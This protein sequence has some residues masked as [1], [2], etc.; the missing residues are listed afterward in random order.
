MAL[1]EHEI[2][3]VRNIRALEGNHRIATGVRAPV[4]PHNDLLIACIRGPRVGERRVGKQLI[5]RW[6]RTRWRTHV[7]GGLCMRNDLLRG[8]SEGDVAARVIA[9]V[10]RVD[11]EVDAAIVRALIETSETR[12][13]FRRKLAVD[14][15][16]GTRIHEESDG[17]AA[18]REVSD[19]TPD[20][21]EYSLRLLLPQRRER[22]AT[23]S[24]GGHS[25]GGQQEFT[26]AERHV[27]LPFRRLCAP[28]IRPSWESARELTE[29]PF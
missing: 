28:K 2:A 3:H 24:A 11:E 1:V 10:V 27:A 15:R 17:A 29:T 26:A 7:L 23:D 25:R 9:V 14:D 13:C 8:A 20:W 19:V 21:R 6:L 16:N 18:H 12:G 4:K 5:G 22:A